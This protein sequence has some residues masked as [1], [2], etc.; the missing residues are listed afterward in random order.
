M[1]LLAGRRPASSPP[2]LAIWLTNATADQSAQSIEIVGF[3]TRTAHVQF[4]DNL[5]GG[6]PVASQEVAGA[7]LRFDFRLPATSS[8]CIVVQP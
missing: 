7:P 2:A 3:P 8:F 4:Y 1:T 5:Q 6:D